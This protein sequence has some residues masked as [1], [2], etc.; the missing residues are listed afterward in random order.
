MGG[1][2]LTDTCELLARGTKL[3][4]YG[5]KPTHTTPLAE[6]VPCRLIEKTQRG[7]NSVTGQ[8]LTTTT[9]KLF[10][11]YDQEIIE[12]DRVTNI[13]LHG[14]QESNQVALLTHHYEV[15]GGALPHRGAMAQHKTVM[16]KKIN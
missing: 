12:G 3:Q 13:R 11:P 15:E 5:I 9:Y 14:N 4:A 6:N 16:L 7:F 8:W 10:L 2:Y 1:L